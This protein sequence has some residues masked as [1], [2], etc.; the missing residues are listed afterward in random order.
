MCDNAEPEP[1]WAG[2]CW[3]EDCRGRVVRHNHVADARLAHP[4]RFGTVG[5]PKI[6]DLPID[7]WINKPAEMEPAEPDANQTA[8]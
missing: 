1:E 8:A 7:A 4:E 5:I 2:S 6:L 3:S